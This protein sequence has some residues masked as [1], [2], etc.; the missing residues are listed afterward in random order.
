ME[1]NLINTS[2]ILSTKHKFIFWHVPKAAGTS[3][4]TVLEPYTTNL[5]HVFGGTQWQR[6]YDSK[7]WIHINQDEFKR[8]IAV[9]GL[10]VKHYREAAFVRHPYNVMVSKYNYNQYPRD[11]VVWKI[12]KR[13]TFDQFIIKTTTRTDG[14]WT[15]FPQ[16]HWTENP[17]TLSGVRVFKVEDFPTAW[18]DFQQY[19]N[20]EL[21]PLP[22]EN[23]SQTLFS[24]SDLTLDQKDHIYN[25][26]KC[27]FDAFGYER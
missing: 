3:V 9:A 27:D 16:T 6:S 25:H 26:F 11:E 20:L 17:L 13:L 4:R 15:T 24:V 7:H 23:R 8:E 5:D 12:P 10:Q 18:L 21:P 22:H 19:I 14:W 1:L 2:M